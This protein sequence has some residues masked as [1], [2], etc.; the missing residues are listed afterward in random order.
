MEKRMSGA[1]WPIQLRLSLHDQS[2]RKTRWLG[3]AK[4]K[5]EKLEIIGRVEQSHLPA[6]RTLRCSGSSRRRSS[7]QRELESAPD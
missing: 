6:R 4:K 3:M 5:F 7:Q 1:I 2:A